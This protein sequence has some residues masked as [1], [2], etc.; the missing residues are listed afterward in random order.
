MSQQH[1][2]G[3]QAWARARVGAC[4]YKTESVCERERE[5]SVGVS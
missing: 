3:E 2:Q 1:V 5:R 4:N